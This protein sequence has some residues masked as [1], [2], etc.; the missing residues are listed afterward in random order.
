MKGRTGRT[1]PPPQPGDTLELLNGKSLIIH[2][3]SD[4]SIIDS[5]G[6]SRSLRHIRQFGKNNHYWL[7]HPYRQKAR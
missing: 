7:E 3:V 6:T 2:S 5:E 1:N 4:W